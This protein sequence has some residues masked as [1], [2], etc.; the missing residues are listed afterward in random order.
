MKKI[1]LIILALLLIAVSAHSAIVIKKKTGGSCSTPS[2]GDVF[3][4]GFVGTG[5]ENA[6]RWTETVGTSGVA[7]ED[8]TLTGSGWSTGACSEGLRIANTV[9]SGGNTY[10]TLEFASTLSLTTS[11]DIYIEFKVQSHSVGEWDG[12]R[13]IRVLDGNTNEALGIRLDNQVDPSFAWQAGGST[14]T[15]YY[16]LTSGTDAI[17]TF[18]IHLDATAAS[19]YVS[20]DGGTNRTLTRAGSASVYGLEIGVLDGVIMD[21]QVGRIWVDRP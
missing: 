5:Y 12:T 8:Y 3:N 7:N 14:S 17:H 15:A 20:I 4:E 1:P 16:A 10:V 19:S 21:I 18:K 13:F 2:D 9:G 6:A 11:L